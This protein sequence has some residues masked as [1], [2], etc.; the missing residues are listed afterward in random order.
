MWRA[1][2][3]WARASTMGLSGLFKEE[4]L[5]RMLRHSL[6]RYPFARRTYAAVSRWRWQQPFIAGAP[7]MVVPCAVPC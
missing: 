3:Q 7:T 4:N 5:P 1:A 2:T 6:P